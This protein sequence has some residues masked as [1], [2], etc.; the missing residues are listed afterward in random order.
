MRWGFTRGGAARPKADEWAA[1]LAVIGLQLDGQARPLREVAVS[2]TGTD[3]RIN[4]LVFSAGRIRYNNWT[5]ILLHLDGSESVAGLTPN[6]WSVQFL[7]IGTLLDRDPRPIRNPCL[8]QIGNGYVIS[9]IAA[10]T[11]A[12]VT[13]WEMATWRSPV[14]P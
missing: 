5:P 4:A 10:N 14:T 12:G 9:A 1:R 7:A 13:Q 2:V 11:T 6:A 8:V 3:V